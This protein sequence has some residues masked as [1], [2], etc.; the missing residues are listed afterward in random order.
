VKVVVDDWLVAGE[1]ACLCVHVMV[2]VAI[3]FYNLT[4][5]CHYEFVQVGPSS[6]LAGL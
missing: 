1:L 3:R 5:S 4:F 2:R 6:L